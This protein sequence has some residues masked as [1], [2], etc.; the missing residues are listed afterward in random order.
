VTDWIDALQRRLLASKAGLLAL[1]REGP[2]SSAAF[3]VLAVAGHDIRDSPLAQRRELLEQLAAN[4][5]PP[6][7]LSP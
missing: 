2:A 3:D 5:E 4:W 1:V 6:L 7:N